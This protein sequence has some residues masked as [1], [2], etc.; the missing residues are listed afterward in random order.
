MRRKEQNKRPPRS[1]GASEGQ[2]DPKKKWAG[3]G[4][5]PERMLTALAYNYAGSL[6]AA[7]TRRTLVVSVGT[8]ASARFPEGEP[9]G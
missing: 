3:L 2:P 1:P 9:S 5:Q 7:T 8:E 6:E 4:G